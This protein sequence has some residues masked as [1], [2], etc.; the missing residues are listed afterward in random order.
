M[1]RY[2][3]H[4]YSWEK[5][6]TNVRHTWSFIGPRG[7]V[8]FHVSILGEYGD[9]A[10]IEYHCFEPRDYQRGDPPSHLDCWLT[11]GRC[12][13]D[14]SSLY[15]IETIWPVVQSLLPGGQHEA[16]FQYLEC[17]ADEQFA[18]DEIRDEQADAPITGEAQEAETGASSG[19]QP[20]VEEANQNTTPQGE[21]S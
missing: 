7:G 19:R 15:A 9:S 6:F 3:H 21:E 8:H 18:R 13:H 12:W 14:G 20:S 11:K 17:I 10:G 5:P 1:T 16:I 4:K 2:R